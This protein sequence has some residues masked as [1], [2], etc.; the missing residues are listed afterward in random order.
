MFS[1]HQW[2]FEL[3][4]NSRGNVRHICCKVG[5][6]ITLHGKKKRKRKRKRKKTNYSRNN[7]L[8]AIKIIIYEIT[9]DH[10]YY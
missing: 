1:L 9:L 8:G 3:V 10:C 7:D 2:T 4:I 6:L 5:T